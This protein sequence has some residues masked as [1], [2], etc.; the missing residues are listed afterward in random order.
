MEDFIIRVNGHDYTITPMIVEDTSY[1][2][3]I[4]IFYTDLP[5][6]KDYQ[7]ET[8]ISRSDYE[9]YDNQN[10]FASNFSYHEEGQINNILS[11]LLWDEIN[12]FFETEL[13]E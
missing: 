7:F 10:A 11:L 2:D 9:E 12:S 4:V 8:T 13:S 6:E 5:F 1:G 3:E